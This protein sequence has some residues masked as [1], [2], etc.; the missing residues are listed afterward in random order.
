MRSIFY[1]LASRR[2]QE[3]SRVSP[4]RSVKLL[5]GAHELL[6]WLVDVDFLEH[7]GHGNKFFLRSVRL[8]SLG[9]GLRG[10]GLLFWRLFG[11]LLNGAAFF[12]L[13]VDILAQLLVHLP[14]LLRAIS[15][16][17]L[18]LLELVSVDLLELGGRILAGVDLHSFR[19][20]F[21][22]LDFLRRLLVGR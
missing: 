6:V 13:D 21:L 12:F 4:L 22:V 1:W 10:N 20:L 17:L 18:L 5:Q 19:L 14:L 7:L 3:L 2:Y 16:G 8:G 9:L 15:H 11:H